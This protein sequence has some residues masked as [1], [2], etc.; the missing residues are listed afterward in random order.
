MKY[1]GNEFPREVEP[2]HDLDFELNNLIYSS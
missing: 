1:F 2:R